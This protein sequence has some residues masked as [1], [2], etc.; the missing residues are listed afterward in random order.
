MYNPPESRIRQDLKKRLISALA[1]SKYPRND[2]LLFFD[3]EKGYSENSDIRRFLWNQIITQVFDNGSRPLS[4]KELMAIYGYPTIGEPSVYLQLTDNK[5][6]EVFENWEL[7]RGE[8]DVIF[9]ANL[10]VPNLA[11]L[12]L[13]ELVHCAN[14]AKER[15]YVIEFIARLE[16]N[17]VHVTNKDDGI[18]SGHQEWLDAI[19]DAV[20]RGVLYYRFGKLPMK[21]DFF[22]TSENMQ[23]YALMGSHPRVLEHLVRLAR[24]TGTNKGKV[25][26]AA[27]EASETSTYVIIDNRLFEVTNYLDRNQVVLPAKIISYPNANNKINGITEEL[28]KEVLKRGFKHRLDLQ[29]I[30]SHIEGILWMVDNN[31]FSV[32]PD[33]I[34]SAIEGKIGRKKFKLNLRR[35][36]L[37]I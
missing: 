33:H 14:L 16:E 28:W 4:G 34:I 8:V 6:K 9:P 23:R 37:A 25:K 22:E 3:P 27:V 2:L 10:E 31:D 21:V 13:K 24:K 17:V 26:Y 15:I 7:V 35:L 29:M 5:T 32:F 20:E 11:K 30:E 12:H 36:R 19:E 18:H 1:A